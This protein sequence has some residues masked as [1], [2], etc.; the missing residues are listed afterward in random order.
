MILKNKYDVVIIGSGLGGLVSANILAKEGFKVCVLEKNRQYGG[1]LQTFVRNKKIFD[2]GVHYVGG[3]DKGQNLHQYF[4]YLGIMEELNLHKLDEDKYD[5]ITFDNDDNEYYHAQGYENFI[6]SLTKQFPKEALA[7]VTYCDKMREICRGFGLYNLEDST[8]Y[9][10]SSLSIK[11]SDYLDSISDDTLFKAVLV[12]SNSLYAG[13]LN[14]PLYVHALSINSYI[15]SSYRF[16]NGGSQISKL[17][18]RRLKE[19][20]GEAYNHQEVVKF[21]FEE[22]TL[23]SVF[24]KEGKEIQASIFVSNI[25]PKIT[26]KMLEGK[27]LRKSFVKRINKIESIISGF[28]LYITFKPETFKYSNYNHYHIKSPKNVYT[29]Q[30]YTKNSWPEGYMISMGV[31]KDQSEWANNMT[32]MTYMNFDEIKEWEH[33]FN[34]VSQESDR[35][36]AYE[37]FKADKTEIFLLELEKKFPNIRDC[38]ASVHVSTPL[39]Y[40]DYIGNNRG[41]MYGYKKDADNTMISFLSPK[42]KLKNLF[43]TGQSVNMHGILG[44]TI[45]AVLTCTHIV[46]REKL[47]ASIKKELEKYDA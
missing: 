16:V 10:M 14:T 7:I 15:E 41:A 20:G 43:L 26:I 3:L 18:L 42:T 46:G 28:S 33:T 5:V 12:G 2:T 21:G 35:G 36:E 13:E 44:V 25:E 30:E 34:T 23:T 11:L 38:M 47:I 40:R 31:H 8:A 24:T 17:L 1:N 32:A 39:S 37:K 22:D 19:N 27:G 45:S 4:S 9:D 6:A 29:A